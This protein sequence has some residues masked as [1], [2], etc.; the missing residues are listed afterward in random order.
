MIS[1]LIPTVSNASA[2]L[3]RISLPPFD[4]GPAPAFRMTIILV[5]SNLLLVL[6][7]SAPGCLT[8]LFPYIDKDL[9]ALDAL[10]FENAAC[11]PRI[12]L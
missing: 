6:S 3:E 2:T 10:Q 5:K 12:V 9:P 4:G 11:K 8:R 7:V 1:A